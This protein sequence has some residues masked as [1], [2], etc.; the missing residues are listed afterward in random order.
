[1]LLALIEIECR[2]SPKVA[3]LGV[4]IGA[5]PA[6]GRPLD[7]LDLSGT[8][9]DPEAVRELMSAFRLCEGTTSGDAA[10]SQSAP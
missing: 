8:P 7:A 4:W 1:V 3:R 2:L 5:D 6:P 9:A 10:S